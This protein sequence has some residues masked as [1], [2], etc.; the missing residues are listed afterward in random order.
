MSMMNLISYSLQVEHSARYTDRPALDGISDVVELAR[1][2]VNVDDQVVPPPVVDGGDGL[3][4]LE[5]FPS[6]RVI[7]VQ[8]SLVHGQQRL[9]PL[10]AIRASGGQE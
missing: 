1:L 4:Q 7:V 10:Q 8:K 9:L 5:L 2:A 3:W 6:L